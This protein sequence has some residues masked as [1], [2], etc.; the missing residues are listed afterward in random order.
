MADVE[1]R[2]GDL[3]D[4]G[5]R[6]EAVED[7]GEV[8]LGRGAAHGEVALEADA[9]HQGP[10]GGRRVGRRGR[11]VL[12]EAD[13]VEGALRLGTIELER[14]VIVVELGVRVS[15]RRRAEGEGDV[16]GAE[17]GEEYALPEGAVAVVEGLVDDVPGVAG[18]GVV[19][20]DIGD[21]GLDGGGK[22][23]WGP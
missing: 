13:D 21:V 1:L 12:H 4:A 6:Q 20:Y 17:G 10:S 9:L 3:L 22:S 15:G 23:L 19:A 14:E 7:G 5:D 18:T 2:D 16:R 8:G 11:G